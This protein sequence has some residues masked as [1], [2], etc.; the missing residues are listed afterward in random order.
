MLLVCGDIQLAVSDFRVP[1]HE[2]LLINTFDAFQVAHVERVLWAQ[3]IRMSSF[4][5]TADFII[6]GLRPSAAICV[7]VSL[8][9]SRATFSSISFRRL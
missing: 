7:S 8:I 4:N 9:P 6:A 1:I 5:F 2:R 3:I